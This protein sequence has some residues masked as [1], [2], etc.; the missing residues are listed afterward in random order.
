MR[1]FKSLKLGDKGPRVVTLQ[2]MLSQALPL[3][4]GLPPTG[5]FGPHTHAAVVQ[6]QTQALGS[7]NVA[8][9]GVVDEATWNALLTSSGRA[10]DPE[11][12]PVGPAAWMIV[13]YREMEKGVHEVVGRVHNEDIVKYHQ[14]TFGGRIVSDETPWCSSF[15]NWCL[16][17]AS[18]AGTN[19]AAAASW[20]NW[21]TEVGAVY[22]AVMVIFNKNKP[23][24]SP[25]TGNHVAFL[26]Q[27][28]ETHYRLLGGNQSDS[29]MVKDYAKAGWRLKG[30]RWPA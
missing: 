5:N 1:A 19:S 4:P 2:N 16:R 28:T 12:P 17:E 10:L 30:R 13:G 27:E 3:R 29:V 6:F 24:D 8:R 22:G 11:P 25:G 20:L 7:A 23:A 21:G 9:M 26:V 14:S 18:V 15:V